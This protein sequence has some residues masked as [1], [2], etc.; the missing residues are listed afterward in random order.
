ML[1]RL[2]NDNIFSVIILIACAAAW[3]SL[4]RV[5]YLGA[6]FPKVII[7]ILAFFT[8]IQLFL[9]FRNPKQQKILDGDKQV[10]MFIMLAGI[11]LYVWSM[12]YI[13]FLLSSM[14]FMAVFFWILSDERS[15]KGAVKTTVLAILV[16]SGFYTLFAK[17]FLVPLPI[18]IFFGG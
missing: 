8:L 14:L 10:Y 15:A 5:T 16:S 3:N 12:T 4:D 11:I 13:G 2:T 9:G 1:S 6:F 17:V 18:G 7:V